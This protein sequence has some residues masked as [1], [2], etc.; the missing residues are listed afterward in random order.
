MADQGIVPVL[1]FDQ[2]WDRELHR[3]LELPKK[4]CVLNPDGMTNLRKFREIVGDHMAVMGDVLS[5]LFAIGTPEEIRNYVRDL[6]RDIGP[7]GLL[8]APGCDTPVNTKPENMKAFVAAAHE[9][10]KG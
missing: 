10:G 6:V 5:T 3:L 4:K 8:L 7:Q 9:F 2:C 1:H